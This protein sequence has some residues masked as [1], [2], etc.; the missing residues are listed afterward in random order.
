[1]ANDITVYSRS[2]TSL[3]FEYDVDNTTRSYNV[4]VHV[5]V[6]IGQITFSQLE[7][8]SNRITTMFVA[9][10]TSLGLSYITAGSLLAGYPYSYEYL[11]TQANTSGPASGWNGAQVVY[12]RPLSPPGYTSTLRNP[13]VWQTSSPL[14]AGT[15]DSG[16][17]AYTTATNVPTYSLVG[18]SLPTGIS[19]NSSGY[20]N[21][22]P[23]V[24]GNFSFTI[25]ATN[26][27]GSSDRTFALYIDPGVTAPSWVDQTLSAD[28]RRGVDY[29]DYVSAS[30]SPTYSISAGALPGGISLNSSTGAVTGIP[31][32]QG[33]SSFTIKALNSAGNVT[34]AF[35][36]SVKPG[37]FRWNGSAWQRVTIMKRWNGSAWV[38]VAAA[39]RWNGSAW[40]SAD[41]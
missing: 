4:Y 21:G 15:K 6:G 11:V 27:G 26:D 20:I 12:R 2:Q 40:V 34:K 30:G 10:G 28:M 16:Y 25:R 22:T 8:E 31:T 7:Q 38:D 9:A 39:K 5:F 17:F 1:M 23:T 32:T 14:P 13:P 19:L 29:E 33:S 18:G 41:L 37:G 24:S 36:I 3:T 35:N